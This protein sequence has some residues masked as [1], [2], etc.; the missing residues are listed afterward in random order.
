MAPSIP[1]LD[2]H[3]FKDLGGSRAV[4]V[5]ALRAAFEEFGFVGIRGHGI[6]P[7]IVRRALATARTLFELPAAVKQRYEIAGGAGQRGYTRLGR[8]KAKDR[9]VT[10]LK[11]FWHVGRE[12]AADDPLAFALKP[13]V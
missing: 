9:T 8:E 1:L 12:A 6:D 3:Y 4:F 11:E 10:D 5:R 13:N 2:L 7:A